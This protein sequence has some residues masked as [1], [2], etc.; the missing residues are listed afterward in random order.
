MPKTEVQLSDD[1][2]AEIDRLVETGDFLNREEAVEELLSRGISAY[3]VDDEP[4]E[5]GEELFTQSMTDQ[6]DPAARQD[7]HDDSFGF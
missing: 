1:V 6:Q 7:A 2:D 3:G 4:E 5:R